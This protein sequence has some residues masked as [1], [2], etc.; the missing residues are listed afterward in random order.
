M[1][2]NA[3]K[4]F[5]EAK[6]IPSQKITVLK[7]GADLEAWGESL[8]EHKINEFKKKL[9]LENK[10]V[11]SYIGTIGMAHRADILL[12]AAQLCNDP[13]IVFMLVGTG[14]KRKEIEDQQ[15]QLQ[16]PNFLL[17]DKV[18][19]DQV[20]YLLAITDASIVHLKASDLFKTV[21]PS[22]IFEAMATRTP[23]VLGVE[24]EVKEIIEEAGAGIPIT[25]ERADELVD[26]VVR[27]K[28][29][30]SFY[31]EMADSGFEHVNMYYD[32][33]K[34]ARKYLHELNKV[35]DK[36]FQPNN[37]ALESTI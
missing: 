31:K 10:F 20:R 16:L 9:G 1:L 12:E 8:D 5:I 19:K 11:A 17:L 33:T 29:N 21:I 6:D 24:G 7:N 35:L 2:T 25:P 37:K 3:F 28:S 18:P 26:A 14:A 32:R 36:P 15:A 27:L 30:P 13:D 4:K 23:I 34:L 22:K